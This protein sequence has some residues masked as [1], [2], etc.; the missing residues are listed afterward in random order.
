MKYCQNEFKCVQNYFYADLF[1]FLFL[2]KYPS[3]TILSMRI[4]NIF[5]HS[6]N[7]VFV[8]GIIIILMMNLKMISVVFNRVQFDLIYE[9]ESNFS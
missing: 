9:Y 3:M 8:L 6:Y 4:H 5:F 1:P 7:Y 2:K